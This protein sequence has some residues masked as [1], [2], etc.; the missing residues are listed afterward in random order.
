[1]INITD[2]KVDLQKS[3][4]KLISALEMTESMQGSNMVKT[5]LFKLTDAVKQHISEC[6]LPEDDIAKTDLFNS[7]K[8]Q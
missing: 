8:A 4:Q 1:M 3:F 6:T 2:N 7:P 5:P